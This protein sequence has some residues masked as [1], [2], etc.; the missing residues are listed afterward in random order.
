MKE[1]LRNQATIIYSGHMGGEIMGP[2]IFPKI[3][4]YKSI[5]EKNYNKIKKILFNHHKWNDPKNV[6][7]LFNQ[8]FAKNLNILASFED[9]IKDLKN[10]KPEQL[11]NYCATWLYLNEADKYTMLCNIRYRNIFRYSLPFLDNDLIDFML[12]VPPKLRIHKKLYKEMLLNKYPELFSFPTKDMFG[13]TLTT[14]NIA[15]ILKRG[16]YFL[17]RK[18]N[19]ISTYLI[20]KNLFSYKKENFL[21]YSD[22]LRTNKEYQNYIRTMINKVNKREFFNQDYIEE[23]WN[24]HQKG[25]KDN[26]KL[27]CLLVSFELFLE[28]YVDNDINEEKK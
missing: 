19:S 17:Q 21:N 28:R 25:R 20:G 11:P 8:T 15:I 24:T 1:Q 27:L 10:I 5:S 26:A 2:E 6:R 16:L 12:Q 4:N 22:L 9:S 18:L 7:S 14:N 23:L 13:F 3:K